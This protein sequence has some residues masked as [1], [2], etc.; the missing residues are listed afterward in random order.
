MNKKNGLSA[1]NMAVLLLF[2]MMGQ[3]AWAVENMYFNLFVFESIAPDLDTVTLMVQ[4]SGVVA[5][6]ITLIAGALSDKT[7]DRKSVV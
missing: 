4:A 2:G 1:R 7:G 6:L 5:T 3:I